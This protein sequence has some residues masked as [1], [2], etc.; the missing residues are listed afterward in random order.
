LEEAVVGGL[1]SL[2]GE[3]LALE[4]GLLHGHLLAGEEEVFQG[5]GGHLQLDLYHHFPTMESLMV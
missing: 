1:V 2:D 3:D 5:A 4:A